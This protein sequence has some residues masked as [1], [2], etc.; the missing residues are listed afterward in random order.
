[1][2]HHINRILKNSLYLY[3]RTFLLMAIGLY[4]S[5]VVL[6][7]LGIEGFG[8]YNVVGSIV[9]I[10]DFI[11]SSL[12]NSSQR[13]LNIGLGKGDLK[14]A[15]EYFSQSV[16]LHFFLSLGVLI[17]LETVGLWF[18]KVKLNVPEGRQSAAF[19][20][21]QLSVLLAFLKINMI[22]F[23][24]VLIAR[25]NMSVYTYISIFEGL[26]KLAIA[27]LIGVNTYFDNL[28]CYA[29]LLVLVQ[30]V[31]FTVHVIYCY[32]KYSESRYKWY[33]NGS[34]CKEM[35]GFVGINTFGYLAWAGGVQGINIII[36]IFLGP[37]VNA[38]K[39]LADTFERLF[40][41]VVNNVF[42]AVKPRIVQSYA[43]DRTSEMLM[44]ADKATIYIYYLLLIVSLPLFLE[45]EA[46]L[47]LW[48]KEVPEYTALFSRMV[49]IKSYFWMLPIPYNQVAV[50]KG[51][52]R[53]IQL[54]GRLI[55]LLALPLSY[56][57]MLYEKDPLYPLIIVAAMSIFFWLYT[58]N[59]V[60]KQ[61]GIP[62]FRYFKKVIIPI[63]RVTICL[64]LSLTL[65][66]WVMWNGYVRLL[67]EGVSSVLFGLLF[68][69]A[70]G[71][72]KEDFSYLS[73]IFIKKIYK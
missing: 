6:D 65:I 10:L 29:F 24:S 64:C 51:K 5:R 72:P 71:M 16:G 49:I 60:N 37:L 43:N 36:N 41:Q 52:I 62:F 46:I 4:T 30:L 73:M 7:V 11:S 9:L 33:W 50:A 45:M 32:K 26:A 18:I 67:M 42:T 55:T 28:I 1:M 22:C 44:L 59:D 57:S 25:E 40:E 69:F 2:S 48:L 34:L 35:W 8:I 70:L 23:Q 63:F 47:A 31:I 14:L 13:Y 12:T 58:V 17:L 20:V 19:W 68:I 56:L 21:F 3:T 38:A 27:F 66:H 39:G 53:N 61:M 54:Y 15:N